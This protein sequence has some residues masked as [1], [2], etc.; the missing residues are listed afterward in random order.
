MVVSTG[1]SDSKNFVDM[2]YSLLGKVFPFLLKL[3]ACDLERLP[4]GA[5]YGRHA[6]THSHRRRQSPTLRGNSARL[7][8]E[9]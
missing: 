5:L 9:P 1:D 6:S 7:P 2:T 8:V 4:D 3:F